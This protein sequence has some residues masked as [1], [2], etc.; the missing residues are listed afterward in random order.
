MIMMDEQVN[1]D[2]VTA[3]RPPLRF[4]IFTLFPAM[5]AGPMSESILRRAQAAGLIDI[6]VHDIRAW[7]TD[8]HRT[9]DDTPYGGGAGMVIRAEPI[10]AGVE[11][12]PQP[13]GADRPRV[14][15]MAAGGRP[16]N[17]ALAHELAGAAGI[18]LICGH[19]EGIDERAIE[20][21]GAE[22]VSV[23]DYVLTGGELPAMVVV[24][25]VARLVPGVIDAA[26]IRQES[27][28]D[29]LLEYPHYTRPETFRGQPVP[30]VLL[31]GHHARIDAWRREQSI[32]RT[33]RHRPDLLRL[34]IERGHLSDAERRLARDL[35]AQPPTGDEDAGE[36]G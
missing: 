30:P 5:F 2:A 26:S 10:V 4:D 20:I 1:A 9:T 12:L 23:G 35:L 34:A 19:Y 15:V 13:T 29:G 8:R 28:G 22:P 17:Q 14:L 11:S 33:A 25:A 21:L 3:S 18:V 36:S 6:H 31:S 7:T 24:D 32:R 16:F 27:F